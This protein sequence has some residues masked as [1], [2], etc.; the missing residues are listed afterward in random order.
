MSSNAPSRREAARDAARRQ[1]EA[2]LASQRRTRTILI[3]AVTALALVLAGLIVWGVVNSRQSQ[4]TGEL[5]Y[6]EGLTEDQPYLPFGEAAEGTP[7]VDVYLDYQCPY[8][9]EFS[10]A[11]GE[12]LQQLIESGQAVVQV[13]PRALLDAATR[14]GDFSSRSSA[15]AACVWEENPENYWEYDR[16]MFE[17][18]PSE[19]SASGMTTDQIIGIAQQ[20]GAGEQAAQCI[21]SERYVPWV[22]QV[23]EPEASETTGG[24]PAVKINGELWEPQGDALYR[25]GSIAEAIGATGSE[26]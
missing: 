21:S 12:E 11:H 23:V 16:L 7:V 24:T 10:M 26:G 15:A 2:E 22:Q 20:A 13:H 6:P 19:Q 1:R 17:N 3:A 18:Q 25:P 14:S 4:P 8:C 9:A 5:V